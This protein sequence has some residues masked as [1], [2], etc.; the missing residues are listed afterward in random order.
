MSLTAC[1]LLGIQLPC[2]KKDVFLLFSSHV[3]LQLN[4]CLLNRFFFPKALII[5]SLAEFIPVSFDF[6]A[7]PVAETTCK[8]KEI[9]ICHSGTF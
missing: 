2:F 6:A 3:D 7:V 5:T 8:M 4:Q 9:T 1:L